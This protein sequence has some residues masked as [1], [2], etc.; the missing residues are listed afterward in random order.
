MKPSKNVLEIVRELHVEA[1][2]SVDQRILQDALAALIRPRPAP[3]DSKAHPTRQDRRKSIIMKITIPVGVAAV[4]AVAVL[5]SVTGYAPKATAAE[6][7]QQA[8]EAASTVKTIHIKG[9]IREVPIVVDLS[10]PDESLVSKVDF[11]HVNIDADFVPLEIWKESGNPSRWRLQTPN[12]FALWDGRRLDNLILTPLPNRCVIS[13][14]MTQEE[15][16]PW[17]RSLLEPESLLASE[18]HKAEQGGLNMQLINRLDSPDANPELVL[19]VDSKASQGAAE[20]GKVIK[21]IDAPDSRRVYRFDAKGKRLLG[22]QVYAH[23]SHGD[24][25]LLETTQIEYDQPIDP[26]IQPFGRKQSSSSGGSAA[27]APSDGVESGRK[28]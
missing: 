28:P 19:T 18:L 27:A 10:K 22:L 17:L 14:A 12:H 25:L 13:F 8:I 26:S 4:V 6:V 15:V 7:L 24:V 9:R 20:A 5:L 2:S 23:T 3:S 1:D 11:E 16:G 21:S